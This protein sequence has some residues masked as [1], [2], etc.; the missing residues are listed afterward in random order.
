MRRV[1]VA[2]HVHSEWSYD[3]AW[4]LPD[5]AR[6]FRRR[7]YDAILMAEHDRGFTP[8]RWVA[9]QSACEAAS[10]ADMV[11]IPGIEYEDADNVV[12]IPVWGVDAPFLG[13]GRETLELLHTAASE[14][15][16]A[17]FAHPWRRAAVLRYRPEWAPLLNA[18]EVWNRK[19][20]GIAPHREATA[21]AQR[22]LL[23]PFV[24]LDFHTSR[25]FFPLAMS[26]DVD[27]AADAGSLVDAIRAGRCRPEILGLSALRFT[28]GLEGITATALEALRRRAAVRL[29]RR[30]ARLATQRRS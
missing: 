13:A 12:H 7:G 4:T 25:Q 19:Y 1:R 14:G 23:T 30:R 29:R 28:R 2:A 21:L 20:D 5:V 11:L 26:M 15:A 3:A 8:E 18:V 22:E 16:V 17:V 10:S 9:Y 24:S 27:G 6:A